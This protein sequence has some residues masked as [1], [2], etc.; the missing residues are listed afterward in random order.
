[1]ADFTKNEKSFRRQTSV[2]ENGVKA[3]IIYFKHDK[4]KIVKYN[5]NY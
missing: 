3:T 2:L 1:M 4:E 5:G